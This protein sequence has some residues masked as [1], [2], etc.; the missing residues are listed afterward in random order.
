MPPSKVSLDKLWITYTLMN[1][2][3]FESTSLTISFKLRI[4][5]S[6]IFLIWLIEDYINEFLKCWIFT[7]SF[8]LRIA[9]LFAA[10]IKI[11]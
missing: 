9:I 8:K 4:S 2:L 7:V 10:S 11:Q 6:N 3:H 1:S 5:I